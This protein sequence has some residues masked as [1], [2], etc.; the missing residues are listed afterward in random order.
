MKNL[1]L[2][3]AL[4]VVSSS[5]TKE[6]DYY[7]TDPI[8]YSAPIVQDSL[9]LFNFRC[10]SLNINYVGL[11]HY[12]S[13]ALQGFSNAVVGKV[14][15]YQIDSLEFT[16]CHD[17]RDGITSLSGRIGNKTFIVLNNKMNICGSYQGL[18]V[19]YS[20]SSI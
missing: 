2:L 17:Y 8:N 4:A 6:D 1:I 16:V 11:Q 5:C 15:Y 10:D 19:T 3:L 12:R 20:L 14:V 13:Q 18:P 7:S 9:W